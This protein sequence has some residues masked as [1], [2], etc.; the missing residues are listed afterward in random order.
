M[1]LKKF[2]TAKNVRLLVLQIYMQAENKHNILEY[3]IEI[4]EQ[5]D[6]ELL[7]ISLVKTIFELFDAERVLFC[8]TRHESPVPHYAI[9]LCE[10]GLRMLTDDADLKEV[11]QD[12]GGFFE[13][14]I[15]SRNYCIRLHRRYEISVYPVQ[16]N[17]KI[18]GF[19]AL[20]R[21]TGSPADSAI[22]TALIRIYHNYLSLL[23][24][25]QRDRLTGLLNR[26]TFDDQILKI[27]ESRK[28]ETALIEPPKSRRHLEGA[29]DGFWLGILDID[30]FKKIN[31]TYGHIYGD[32]VL[33]LIARLMKKTFRADDYLFRYG[34]EEFVAI[35]RT[36]SEKE[37]I[38]TFERFRMSVETYRL[39]TVGSITV[40]IGIVQITADEVPTVFVGHAD[41]ALYFAKTNGKNRVCVYEKLI[42]QGLLTSAIQYGRVE[43]F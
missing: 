36:V 3:I 11:R 28:E 6:A 40:S 30:D 23:G 34:G 21:N 8:K 7:E 14:V 24:E 35:I 1:P 41:Q 26:K 29:A 31:D 25:S 22:I 32:E 2:E 18:V 37:A 42:E 33:I 5:R 15:N 20:Y 19:I 13:D 12:L 4:T 9:C 10:D 16:F 27:I 17:R 43:I 38:A 39:P